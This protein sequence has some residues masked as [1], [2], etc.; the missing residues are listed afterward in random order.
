VIVA[1]G[2]HT[3]GDALPFMEQHYVSGIRGREALLRADWAKTGD[4]FPVP[5]VLDER[6]QWLLRHRLSLYRPGAR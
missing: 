6:R 4:I 5:P 2:A 3:W 1:A